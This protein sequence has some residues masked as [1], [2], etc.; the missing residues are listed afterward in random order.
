MGHHGPS[1]PSWFFLHTL[2][3]KIM[4]LI[5]L[6]VVTIEIFVVNVHP[7]NRKLVSTEI[8]MQFYLV[9]R[10]FP[11][12]KFPGIR[13]QDCSPTNLNTTVPPTDLNTYLGFLLPQITI[14]VFCYVCLFVIYRNDRYT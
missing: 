5:S 14:G 11:T 13:F 3:L 4:L 2:C 10:H 6:K 12:R 9:L 1:W 7:N 8:L